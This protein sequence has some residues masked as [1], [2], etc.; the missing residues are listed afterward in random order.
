M[1]VLPYL[2]QSQRTTYDITVAAD[3]VPAGT[4]RACRVTTTNFRLM[5][6]TCVMVQEGCFICTGV[7]CRPA[8]NT[9]PIYMYVGVILPVGFV[10]TS[11]EY[12]SLVL[13]CLTTSIHL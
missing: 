1:Q 2:R 7:F 10:H 3:I 9:G 13:V 5:Y 12:L 11:D 6:Y 8:Y 4:G